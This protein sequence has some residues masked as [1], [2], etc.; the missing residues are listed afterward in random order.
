[1]EENRI[2]K[3]ALIVI[4]GSAGSLD[5]LLQLLPAIGL[6][7]SIPII[8]VLHRKSSNDNLLADLLSSRTHLKVKEADEKEPVRPG[9][10][11]IAPA[12]YHLLL[13]ADRTFSLDYSEKVNYSRPSIDVVF[14]SA[15]EVYGPSLVCFLLSGANSDGTE[16]FRTVQEKGGTT[17]AQDPDTAEVDYMPR[18][19]ILQHCADKV[20][21]REEMAAYINSL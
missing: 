7:F 4:G 14:H 15:A 17:I 11:Y 10:I 16:G 21:T 18:N 2:K 8:I 5:V 3:T 9:H 13:E 12:D 20:L 1:M 6:E 19:A